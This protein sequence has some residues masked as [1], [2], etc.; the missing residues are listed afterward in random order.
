MF[1]NRQRWCFIAI[2]LF[3]EIDGIPA[4]KV[5]LK[6]LTREQ[7]K[8]NVNHRVRRILPK[9]GELIFF[10]IENLVS[11]RVSLKKHT[12]SRK[13]CQALQNCMV[14]NFSIA[15]TLLSPQY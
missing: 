7:I 15:P 2:F 8:S 12:L 3:D 10:F 9:F 14:Q 11:L 1:I 6:C 13:L 4:G 5:S